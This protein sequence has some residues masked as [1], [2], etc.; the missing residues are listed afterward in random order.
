MEA[1]DKSV[2][3]PERDLKSPFLLPIEKIVQ[4]PGR[5]QVIV[6]TVNRGILKKGESFEI[7]G[8]DVVVKTVATEM[9]VFKNAV[10]EC[11]AGENV[12]ILARGLKSGSIT[13]GMM[14][15]ATNSVQQ[16]DSFE[17][18]VYM[19]NK[20]EGGRPKPIMNGY[21]QPFYTKTITIDACL[22]LKDGKEMLMPGDYANVNFLI[23][24]PLVILPGDRFTIREGNS[25]TSLTGVVSK[26][27]P[28][29]DTKIKGFNVHV[30]KNTQMR[31]SKTTNENKPS[32]TDKAAKK[33]K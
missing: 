30:A 6:G 11:K 14:A 26:I 27:L 5:G 3:L 21:V 22:Q 17:A 10:N 31:T 8:Y 4:I 29:S 28:K 16:T 2:P 25:L 20:N 13:R 23:K 18:S 1:I 19:L 12:G 32:T 7:S 15:I 33:G 24:K 9:H